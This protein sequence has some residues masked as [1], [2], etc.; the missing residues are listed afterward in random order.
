MLSVKTY[1]SHEI[2]VLKYFLHSP[3]RREEGGGITLSKYKPVR[4][5]T[6]APKNLQWI[7]IINA[8]CLLLKTDFWKG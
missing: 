3:G 8:Q 5:T 2:I 1:Y 6:P 7:D 4:T